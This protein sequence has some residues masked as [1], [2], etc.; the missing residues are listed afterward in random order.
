MSDWHHRHSQPL[1]SQRQAVA[2]GRE[3]VPPALTRRGDLCERSIVDVRI[4]PLQ[5]Q[6]IDGTIGATCPIPV[7]NYGCPI[8]ID[9]RNVTITHTELIVLTNIITTYFSLSN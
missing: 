1:Q 4:N 6:R 7:G 3:V 5:S 8:T 9:L 2:R